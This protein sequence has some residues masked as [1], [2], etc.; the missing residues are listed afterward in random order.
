MAD[1][2]AIKDQN[3]VY[4]VIVLLQKIQSCSWNSFKLNEIVKLEKCLQEVIRDDA[5]ICT[6]I[7]KLSNDAVFVEPNAKFK[8]LNRNVDD[9]RAD[10]K[11]IQETRNIEKKIEDLDNQIECNQIKLKQLS[12][13]EHEIDLRILDLHKSISKVERTSAASYQ[14]CQILLEQ[15]Q[16]S[17]GKTLDSIQERIPNFV[18]SIPESDL[19]QQCN[20]LATS[21]RKLPIRYLKNSYKHL[22]Q[23]SARIQFSYSVKT[24]MV[25]KFQKYL[26]SFKPL[27]GILLAIDNVY[28]TEMP[29]VKELLEGFEGFVEEFDKPRLAEAPKRTTI[30]R[31]DTCPCEQPT[32]VSSPCELVEDLEF[33]KLYKSVS[34]CIY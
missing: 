20:K 14:E 22:Q 19:V 13:N 24:S 6:V 30:K 15:V 27:Y 26:N 3:R 34:I 10:F 29:E 2:C 5:N 7:R 17:L 1:G 8:Y 25:D 12:Q 4:S 16:M 33:E 28:S 11:L 23:H 31:H 21:Y 18:H 32:L 9:K